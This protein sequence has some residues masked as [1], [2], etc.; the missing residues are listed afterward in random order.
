MEDTV[1]RIM[2]FW[3]NTIARNVFNNKKVLI[4][5]H[6]N[7][8]RAIFK[9]LQNISDDDI[10]KFKVPNAMPMVYEFDERMAFVNNYTLMDVNAYTLKKEDPTLSYN[11]ISI[12]KYKVVDDYIRMEQA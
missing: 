3:Y 1:N 12:D 5:A 7:S 8:L 9:H 4:V 2:P 6:K 11:N 10:K